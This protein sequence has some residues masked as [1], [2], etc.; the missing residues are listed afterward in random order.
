M[1]ADLVPIRLS[2]TAGDRYTLWAPRWRDA[3]D[4]WE[5]FLGHDDELYGFHTVADLVAFVR[6]SRANDLTDHPGWAKL[7]E[8]NAHQLEPAKNRSFDLVAVEEL[9]AEDPTKKS[10]RTLAGALA[11]VSSLGSVCEL[12]AVTKFFNGNPSL[13]TL[14]GG[15][16]QFTGRAGSSRWAG[17]GEIVARNWDAVLDAIDAVVATPDVDSAAAA[18]AAD[19][20]AEPAPEEPDEDDPTTDEPATVD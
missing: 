14:T 16:E 6:T 9:L 11:V 12:T 17:I 13:G 15:F 5:A 18:R 2:L 20:L 3:G 19:E 4:E 7:T 1:V 8:A 10:V